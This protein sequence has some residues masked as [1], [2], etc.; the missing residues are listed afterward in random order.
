MTLLDDVSQTY[1]Q[2]K[3]DVFFVG[4]MFQ[5]NPGLVW[6]FADQLGVEVRQAGQI[7]WGFKGRARLP[8]KKQ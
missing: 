8:D 1:I 6:A 7:E 2:G 5:K 4:R 3:V